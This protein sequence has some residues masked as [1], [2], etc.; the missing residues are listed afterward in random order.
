MEKIQ[1]AVE[2][3]NKQNS[4]KNIPDA[5]NEFAIEILKW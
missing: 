2:F 3:W 4:M 5:L 1:G